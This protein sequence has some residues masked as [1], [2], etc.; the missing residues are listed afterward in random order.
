MNPE[1]SSKLE[2]LKDILRGTGG[3]AVAFSGG[4]DSSLLLTV[5]YEMLGWRCLAVIAT[6]STYPERECAQAIQ[7]VTERKI[8]HVVVSSEELDIPGFS[9]NPRNRCY[10][11]KSELFRKVRGQ[12]DAHGLGWI[13]DGT[14]ADD[15]RD[16]R[17]GMTAAREMGVISPLLEAG[18]TKE[19]IRTISREVYNLPTADKPSMACLASRFPYGSPITPE[20]LAQVERVE[21]FLNQVGFRVYRARHHGD[22]LR[23]ELGPREMEA[24]MRGEMRCAILANAKENGFVYVTLDLEGYR[25]GSMNEAPLETAERI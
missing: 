7:F 1:I 15:T 23:L 2:H 16:Y 20:K 13:A 4:V 14:N 11:C 9:A 22:I 12:A 21:E 24:A 5:A 8:P 18:L 6:S 17:P 19:E 10:H 25:T 3:C